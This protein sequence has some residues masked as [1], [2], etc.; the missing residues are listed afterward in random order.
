MPITIENTN[1]KINQSVNKFKLNANIDR[2]IENG[3]TNRHIS[4]IATITTYIALI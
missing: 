4:V 3:K 1:L 2:S